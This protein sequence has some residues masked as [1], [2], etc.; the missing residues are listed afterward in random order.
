V[1]NR[2][3]LDEMNPPKEKIA[4][5]L[6]RRHAAQS[7][8]LNFKRVDACPEDVFN[9]ILWHAM[10]GSSVPYPAWA[11]TARPDDDD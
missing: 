7:A 6:L 5:P 2:I 8:R 9:R 10:K 4:D 3:A 1:P 11:V